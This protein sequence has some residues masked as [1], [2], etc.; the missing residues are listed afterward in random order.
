MEIM[1]IHLG[2]EDIS[3]KT[4]YINLGTAYDGLKQYTKAEKYLSLAMKVRKA[5]LPKQNP[6]IADCVRPINGIAI[7]FNRFHIGSQCCY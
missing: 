7:E 1:K 6:D 5:H 4:T 2:E 3:I